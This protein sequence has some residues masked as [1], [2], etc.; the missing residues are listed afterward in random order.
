MTIDNVIVLSA[1]QGSRLRPLTDHCP[2]CMVKFQGRTL[3]EHQLEIYQKYGLGDVTVVCGYESSSVKADGIRKVVNE[4]F[5]T[6]N[7]VHSLFCAEE[8]M[9]GNLLIAYGDIVFKPEVV[10]SILEGKGDIRVVVDR[11]WRELWSQRM[12]NP[13]ADAE[14]M[15]LVD[16]DRIKELGKKPQSYDEIEGQYIGMVL[17]SKE[18]IEQVKEHYQSLD[19]NAQYDG[20]SFGNMYMTSFVQGLID[21][22]FDVRASFIDGGWLEFD[23]PGD[24]ALQFVTAS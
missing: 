7:M 3:L 23:E 19:R 14:T 17:I 6:T 9:N 5:S 22:G 15:K 4:D 11:C 8:F 18:V 12:E 24:L 20:K 16:G 10:G 1:G 21:A 13:L 2:K